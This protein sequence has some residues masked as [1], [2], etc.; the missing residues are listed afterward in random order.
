MRSPSS[1]S[2]AFGVLGAIEPMQ[3]HASRIRVR[4]GG[5]VERALQPRHEAVHGRLIRPAHARRR[6]HAAA[7]LPHGFLPHV[8]VVGQMREVQGVERDVGGL[9]ALV[10]TRHAVLVEERALRRLGRRGRAPARR[11]AASGCA[12][13]RP[14]ST[15]STLRPQSKSQDD[16]SARLRGFCVDRRRFIA[17]RL[18]NPA[19]LAHVQPHAPIGRGHEEVRIPPLRVVALSSGPR[20]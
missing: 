17:I 19:Q 2:I 20:Q 8:R 4:R 15:Q 13:R 6:H 3:R 1:S 9:G 12:A 16:S 7:K 18:N 10:V 5:L 11:A 14:R